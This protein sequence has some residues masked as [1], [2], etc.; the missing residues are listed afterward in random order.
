MIGIHAL[1]GT[2]SS[3]TMV[4]PNEHVKQWSNPMTR[5]NHGE[6]Q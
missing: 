1:V 4:K 2:D 3:Q 5:S 6:T